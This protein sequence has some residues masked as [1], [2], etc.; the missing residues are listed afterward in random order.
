MKTGHF[1][2]PTTGKHK[3]G[4]AGLGPDYAN[5]P[6]RRERAGHERSSNTSSA[7][8]QKRHRGLE[9]PTNPARKM[10]PAGGIEIFRRIENTQLIDFSRRQ[11][12]R[13]RQNCACLERISNAGFSFSCQFCGVSLERRK[14][15]NRTNRLT[16]T[17]KMGALPP[18]ASTVA[19]LR[20]TK[21]QP[22]GS[23]FGPTCRLTS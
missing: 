15:S 20:L 17:S 7:N 21:G 1:N 19:T 12:H 2:L 13:T 11:K 8:P 23:L 3:L 10:V 16:L 5:E 6:L 14:I 18:A 9:S 4:Q 22:C